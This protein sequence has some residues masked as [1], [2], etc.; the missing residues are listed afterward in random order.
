MRSSFKTIVGLEIHA[1][2][3]SISKA[4]SRAPVSFAAPPNT[5]VDLVDSAT[6][7][8]YPVYNQRCLKAGVLTSS[9]LNM[10]ISPTLTFDRKHYFYH[11]LPLGY[12]ITQEHNP[13]GSNGFLDVFL[14]EDEKR[15]VENKD[16]WSQ[17][18]ELTRL[19]LEHD[20]GKS[21]HTAPDMTLVDLNRCGI[22]LMEIVTAPNIHSSAI[23]VRF[24]KDLI[25]ILTS[26][27]VCDGNLSEGSLRVDANINVVDEISGRKTP[28]CEV[29]NINGLRFLGKAIDY[30]VV[31]QSNILAEG[32]ENEMQM[33]TRNFDPQTGMTIPLRVKEGN[34]EYRFLPE[35]DLPPFHITKDF[36]SAIQTDMPKLPKEKINDIVNQHNISP[37]QAYLLYDHEGGLDYFTET[38]MEGQRKGIVQPNKLASFI[39]SDIFSISNAK[40][41]H[42]CEVATP[43]QLCD[44][45]SLVSDNTISMRSAKT[46]LPLLTEAPSKSVKDVA[47]DLDLVQLSDENVLE[48]LASEVVEKHDKQRNKFLKGQEGVIGFFVGQIMKQ[49]GGKANPQQTKALVVN[50]LE[51]YRKMI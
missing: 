29:K 51:R 11:D 9:A 39:V 19:Q 32:K 34:V 5:N 45:L 14:T 18:V 8:S 33:E 50:E 13:L 44:L 1:R 2:I 47:N 26:L 30:E 41:I 46:I 15:L 49:T 3:N 35:P 28:R 36:V 10:N 38:F 43:S 22:G 21:L 37:Q 24:V 23:A 25:A 31:R 42:V 4:F 16:E 7:G 17:R 6:P 48:R 12:Q 27:E 40:K 20:S